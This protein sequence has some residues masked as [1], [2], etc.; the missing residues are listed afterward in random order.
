MRRTVPIWMKKREMGIVFLRIR[1]LD[2]SEDV[3]RAMR[4]YK[5]ITPVLDD[6]RWAL[7]W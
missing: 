5:C 1:Q 7:T 3:H 4:A 6:V 2:V